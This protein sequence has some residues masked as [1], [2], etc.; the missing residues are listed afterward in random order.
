MSTTAPL[1]AAGWHLG[2]C[3]HA[4]EGGAQ[5]VTTIDGLVKLNS[6]LWKDCR[7]QDFN[8]DPRNR[9]KLLVLAEDIQ[10]MIERERR[11]E[12]GEEERL[13]AL[14]KDDGFGRAAEKFAAVCHKTESAGRSDR[15]SAGDLIGDHN[16]V[17]LGPQPTCARSVRRFSSRP[18]RMSAWRCA[19]RRARFCARSDHARAEPPDLDGVCAQ[20]TNEAFT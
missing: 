4:H 20:R 5:P 16:G 8:D 2:R 1:P 17:L 13:R 18:S 3:R 11:L 12:P 19:R 10:G 7:L 15:R 14:T 6:A 9:G